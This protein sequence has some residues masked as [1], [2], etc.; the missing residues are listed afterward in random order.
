MRQG[1]QNSDW[2]NYYCI[3][4]VTYLPHP[5]VFPDLS[6]SWPVWPAHLSLPSEWKPQPTKMQPL[7]FQCIYHLSIELGPEKAL[8]EQLRESEHSLVTTL[9]LGLLINCLELLLTHCFTG[10]DL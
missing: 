10:A 5:Q 1:V 8:S 2:L 7:P 4:I 3:I 6:P 9:L